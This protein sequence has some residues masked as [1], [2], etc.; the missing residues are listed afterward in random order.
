MD[1]QIR[2]ICQATGLIASACNDLHLSGNS[3]TQQPSAISPTNILPLHLQLVLGARRL[4]TSV[5]QGDYV[6]HCPAIPIGPSCL[7]V[8]NDSTF[9]CRAFPGPR[10]LTHC[11]YLN[12]L[13]LRPPQWSDSAEDFRWRQSHQL[14]LRYG[15]VLQLH[16]PH[17]TQNTEHQS[18][19]NLM[20]R[21]NSDDLFNHR[22]HNSHQT[23]R[24][25]E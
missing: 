15:D 19:W 2:S 3:H 14:Q 9:N 24:M 11:H 5:A 7:Q 18:L 4:A 25:V 6:Q 13:A 10:V 17:N 22:S 20:R 16:P 1:D 21:E 8:F 12:H 23:C